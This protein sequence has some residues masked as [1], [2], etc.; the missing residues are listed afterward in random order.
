MRMAGFCLALLIA[1][2]V[3]ACSQGVPVAKACRK[4]PQ[5][6]YFPVGSFTDLLRD[7]PYNIRW[8]G[9]D[10]DSAIRYRFSNYLS[11]MQEPS[12]FCGAL[13][14]AETYR[15][16]WLR[17]WHDNIAVRIFRRAGRYGLE[18]VV[19]DHD[20]IPK[21]PHDGMAGHRPGKIIKRV[22]KELS[23]A[24]WSRLVA[25]L[26]QKPFWTMK[27][28]VGDLIGIDGAEWIVEARREGRYHVV[29]RYA[30]ADGLSDIGDV[31][32]ELA[33]LQEG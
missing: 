11:A 29:A 9:F 13:E 30:G 32:L 24:Q 17:T 18:A 14:D 19:L 26:H 22:T 12:L 8:D 15:F 16:V 28:G 1:V 6:R 27:T 31:F 33:S 21:H 10:D 3:T 4:A 20:Q 7:F 25:A 2:A 23:L 5:D